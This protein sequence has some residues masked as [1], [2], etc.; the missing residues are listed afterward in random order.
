M[1][2][3]GISII[4]KDVIRLR[5]FYVKILNVPFEG[6]DVFSL[7][8]AKGAELSICAISIMQEMAPE[9]M[10]NASNGSHILEFQVNSIDEVDSFYT[11]LMDLG[12][13]IVKVPTTQLWGRHSVWIR[14]PDGNIVNFFCNV[15]KGK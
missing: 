9:S 8:K 6:D 4:T 11:Q 10:K 3:I 5:D 14:D 15:K 2:L 1:K 13:Q 7:I 12:V